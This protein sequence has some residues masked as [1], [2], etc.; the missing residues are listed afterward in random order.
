M[1]A[2]P[3]LRFLLLWIAIA[4]AA[5]E[6]YCDSWRL[7]VETNNAGSWRTVPPPCRGFV[8]EYM[9]GERY[10]SDS[11]VVA[12]ESLA[13]AKSVQIT[14]DGKDAW[15]FDVDETL[16]SNIPYYASTGYGSK[17]FN[18]TSFNEWVNLA[19]APALP[20]SLRLYE[21]LLIL[22]F[23]MILLTGRTESQ[24]KITEDNLLLTGYGYWKRLILREAL[25]LGKPAVK[26][27]SERRAELEGE[28]LRIHGNSGDQWSDLLGSTLARRSF[29]LPNP[30]YYID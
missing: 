1:G 13:F 6:L 30:M 4:A 17:L 15:I 23:Q 10:E 5:D 19:S 29:K 27:K 26:F 12:L 25:D 8:E 14:D 22:G 11:N 20:A 2:S 21:D 9:S 24:R 7:S 3:S 16:L 28:G 18:V